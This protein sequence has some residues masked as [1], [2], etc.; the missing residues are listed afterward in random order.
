MR[1]FKIGDIV[2]VR[3]AGGLCYDGIVRGLFYL[4]FIGESYYAVT[5]PGW[6]ETNYRRVVVPLELVHESMLD[7]RESENPIEDNDDDDCPTVGET[8]E[9]RIGEIMGVDNSDNI[10]ELE[11][12]RKENEAEPRI[13]NGMIAP[14]GV[15]NENYGNS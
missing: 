5:G 8:H 15:V 6:S 13:V 2:I 11:A 10:A 3:K 12:L 4:D 1:Y 14:R 9:E 7:I